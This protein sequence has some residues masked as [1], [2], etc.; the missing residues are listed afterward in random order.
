MKFFFISWCWQAS[1]KILV[2]PRK[3][4]PVK[5]PRLSNSI[6]Y[7]VAQSRTRLKRL[8]SS[9]SSNSS[10]RGLHPLYIIDSSTRITRNKEEY[11]I[12]ME[13]SSYQGKCENKNLYISNSSNIASKN[14][15][16]SSHGT[17][18]K[19]DLMIDHKA[20]LN[21]SH[22]DCYLNIV[23]FSKKWIIK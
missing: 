16:S 10:S 3:K 8:S 18:N 13:E 17:F 6:P 19:I 15:F 20:S 7:G 9:S 23:R 4:G 22:P 2:P 5:Q 21:K 1:I 14:I 12:I 11:F